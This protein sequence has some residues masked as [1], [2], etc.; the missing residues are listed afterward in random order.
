MYVCIAF[1][2]FLL[3]FFFPGK[4]GLGTSPDIEVPLQLKSQSLV[5]KIQINTN[6]VTGDAW[7]NLLDI[8]IR[9]G[10]GE[11]VD[12]GKTGNVYFGNRQDLGG[13]PK[14]NL[15]DDETG[16][17]PEQRSFG[18]SSRSPENLVINLGKEVDVGS[19][20]ITNRNDCC[21]DRIGKYRLAVYH[22]SE[23][24]GEVSLAELAYKGKTIRYNLNH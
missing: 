16:R 20:Q 6:V 13:Y 23:I 24:L 5:T 4:E 22:N 1:F 3:L 18:H 10:K 12:Y 14:T 7:I 11:I 21:W 17:T 8:T 15:W 2:L 19:I 9:D